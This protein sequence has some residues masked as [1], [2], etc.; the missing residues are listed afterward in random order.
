MSEK[1]LIEVKNCEFSSFD[2]INLKVDASAFYPGLE[3]YYNDGYYPFIR[4]ADVDN[5]IDYD[6]CI[7]I[8]EQIVE[9]GEFST[10][11]KVYEGDILITKGG[12]IGRVALVE[13]E[14]AVTRDL[15]FL[16]SSS[17]K[18]YEYKFLYLYLSTNFCNDLMI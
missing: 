8:P 13:K 6:N 18:D 4:V 14:A 9:T 15:I 11:K 5:F 2:K 7:K 10:L 12:S 16:N 3:Q 17:I 1:K